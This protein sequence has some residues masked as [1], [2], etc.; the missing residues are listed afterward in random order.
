[1]RIRAGA[2]HAFVDGCF[3]GLR[4]TQRANLGLCI[5]ALLAHA[6]L[7]LSD[8]GRSFPM[9]RHHRHRV[10][11]VYRFLSNDHV[12]PLAAHV[13]Y[14]R[15]HLALDQRAEPLPIIL[16]DTVVWGMWVVLFAA[17]PRRGRALPLAW[18]AYD[19][20]T[21]R[22][23]QNRIEEE[24]ITELADC[25]APIRIVLIAD[26]GFARASLLRLL[27]QRGIDFVVRIDRETHIHWRGRSKPAGQYRPRLDATRL[28]TDAAYHREE[29]IPIT[30]AVCHARGAEEPWYLASSLD[31]AT[32]IR[33]LYERRV[34]IEESFR[35]LKS[36]LGLESIQL[37]NA[38]RIERLLLAL[39]IVYRLLT[40]LGAALAR[41]D[42]PQAYVAWK[43]ISIFLI[44][45]RAADNHPALLL[46]LLRRL[47][48][49]SG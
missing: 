12:S 35:D 37:R 6:R 18:R 21:I 16:D 45:F 3:G 27:R 46:R 4:K 5:L 2:V 22:D 36:H 41:R 17:I 26:R 44:G 49:Q 25:L 40:L 28:L 9:C 29:Q 8:L 34:T 38:E 13:G 42:G 1:M 7:T 47:A 33:R 30:F 23:S 43:T 14:L 32:R 19:R 31:Q 15:A 24:F 10:K 11:R 48:Q 20:A 39:I